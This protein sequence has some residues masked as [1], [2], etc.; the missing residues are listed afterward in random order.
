MLRLGFKAFL[1]ILQIEYVLDLNSP[2][3]GS[4][5]ILMSNS[6]LRSLRSLSRFLSP[7]S[8]SRDLE[9]SR[10]SR[11]RSERS[12]KKKSLRFSPK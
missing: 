7:R 12:L 2:S 11:L 9:R 5:L 6:G 4:S 1:H 8:L 10:L 3:I